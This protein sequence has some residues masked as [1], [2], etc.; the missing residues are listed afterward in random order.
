MA[1]SITL[2]YCN[3]NASNGRA[4]E[5]LLSDIYTMWPNQNKNYPQK[6]CMRCARNQIIN[7]A[8]TIEEINELIQKAG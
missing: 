8:E 6:T 1:K 4:F 3:T 7:V 2:H 5:I